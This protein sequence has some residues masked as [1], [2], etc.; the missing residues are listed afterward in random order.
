MKGISTNHFW[1][2]KIEVREAPVAGKTYNTFSRPCKAAMP[3]P[4]IP[5]FSRGKKIHNKQA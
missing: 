2:K 1:Q 4:G 5:V 3:H